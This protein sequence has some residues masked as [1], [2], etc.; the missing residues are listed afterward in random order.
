MNSK[1]ISSSSYVCM[2]FFK[3][4]L[5]PT[6]NFTP[7][8]MSENGFSLTRIFP[9]NDSIVVSALMRENTGQRELIIRYVLLSV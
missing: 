7:Q 1:A 3:I 6:K 8:N 2:R 5:I 4:F 9:Y